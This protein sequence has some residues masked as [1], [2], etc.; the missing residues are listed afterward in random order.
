MTAFLSYTFKPLQELKGKTSRVNSVKTSASLHSIRFTLFVG[1]FFIGFLL[2]ARAADTNEIQELWQNSPHANRDSESF[3]HWDTEGQIPSDCALCHSTAGFLDYLGN[4]DSNE[5]TVE[6]AHPIGSVIECSACHNNSIAQWPEV[7]FPSGEII[8]NTGSSTSCTVCHQGRQSTVGVNAKLENLPPDSVSSELQFL[9]I[10]YRAAAATLFGT[11]TKGGYEYANKRYA[12]KFAHPAPLNNCAGC[13]DPHALTVDA[14]NCV[15][16]H[17]GLRPDSLAS[18]RTNLIDIDLDGDIKEPIADELYTVYETLGIAIT[19]Y[20]IENSKMPIAY[21]SDDYP[22]FFN[23][24]DGSGDAEA[25]ESKYPNRYQSWTPRLLRAAYNYQ[26][27]SK[28]PGAW[29]HNPRYVAQ[30]MIDSID[31][32]STRIKTALPNYNRP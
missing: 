32:I 4:D 18:I 13:H 8:P 7:Q 11:E 9:N 10:H 20:S 2:T 6:T 31:D 3:R 21:G 14:A 15:A 5:G 12:V 25:S 22:Y 26:F 1:I 29:A 16:C 24:I 27:F 30:L 28:D 19:L 23:D 17:S